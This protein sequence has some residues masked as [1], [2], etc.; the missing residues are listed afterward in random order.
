MTALIDM[1]AKCG[2]KSSAERVFTNGIISKDVI[3]W[4]SM[5]TGYGVHGHGDR[6]V[7]FYRIMIEDRVR[8]NGII[9]VSLIMACRHSGLVEEGIKLFYSMET[10]HKI[11]PTY[12]CPV[13]LLG[14][15]GWLEEASTK[16]LLH[17]EVMFSKHC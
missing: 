10:Y 8:P 16:C 14:R 7:K 5:I 13:D 17:P 12:A 9:F 2:K 4:N 6:S 1:Y 15:A 11:R 3:L